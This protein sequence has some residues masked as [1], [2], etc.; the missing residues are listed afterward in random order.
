MR[1]PVPSSPKMPLLLFFALTFVLAWGCWIPLVLVSRG[2][3]QMPSGVQFALQLAGSFAPFVAV[4]VSLCID[5][6]W[7][8]MREFARRCLRYRIEIDYLVAALLL[9]PLLG[10][11]AAWIYAHAGG[12]PFAL[13]VSAAQIP[14]L[15]VMMFFIGGAVNEEFGWAYAIDRLQRGRTLLSAALLL[16]VIWAAWHLPLFFISGVTQSYLPMWS[17]LLFAVAARLLFVWAYESNGK[18][19][20]VTLLFHTTLNL[21]LNLFALVDRS[22]QRNERGFIALAVLVAAVAAIVACTARRYRSG[23]VLPPEKRKAP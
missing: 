17:F 5:G 23:V 14:L 21:T 11:I 2:V 12:P 7:P 3:L 8:V 16:G 13:A 19:L 22:P 1:M 18:S 9:L 10:G 15:F 6:G 20:L 4:F